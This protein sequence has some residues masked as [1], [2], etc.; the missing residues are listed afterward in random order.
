MFRDPGSGIRTG[1]CATRRRGAGRLRYR[2]ECPICL[3][4]TREA[5]HI[6]D[7][8]KEHRVCSGCLSES[9]VPLPDGFRSLLLCPFP[10]CDR[11]APGGEE[12]FALYRLRGKE[13]IGA[14]GAL[15]MPVGDAEHIDQVVGWTS[16]LGGNVVETL[17]SDREAHSA[18]EVRERL[19]DY[20][21]TNEALERLRRSAENDYL[22]VQG[23]G[24]RIRAPDEPALF[25]PNTRTV[26]IGGVVQCA[27]CRDA[28]TPLKAAVRVL[29]GE[30]TWGALPALRCCR[31]CN[32][33]DLAEFW[34]A[35]GVV[36]AAQPLNTGLLAALGA[37]GRALWRLCTPRTVPC[38][39]C[40][41][42]IQR[43]SGCNHMIHTRSMGC[44]RETHFCFSC[45]KLRDPFLRESACK[46]IS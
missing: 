30:A 46:C 9:T 17:F 31:A 22:F 18:P 34:A 1:T 10:D 13:L 19:H 14:D 15:R 23:R 45:G 11:C 28:P 35:R 37:A 36:R 4:P 43:I 27:A 39:A 20:G 5:I 24:Y 38:P 33:D 21:L 16:F 40:G 3:E 7:C 42:L 25:P 12:S 44:V 2:W 41:M 26:R 32:A 29:I 8:G 6:R